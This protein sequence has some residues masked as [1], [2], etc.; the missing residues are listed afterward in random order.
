MLKLSKGKFPN[1][2]EFTKHLSSKT[3]TI[4]APTVWYKGT[5]PVYRIVSNHDGAMAALAIIGSMIANGDDHPH[6]KDSYIFVHVWRFT[7]S[8]EKCNGGKSVFGIQFNNVI[9]LYYFLYFGFTMFSKD[10]IVQELTYS[11]LKDLG[12]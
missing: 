12:Y 9:S 2:Y 5:E 4:G 6:G 3:Y 1:R 7:D 11:I 10:E 8:C